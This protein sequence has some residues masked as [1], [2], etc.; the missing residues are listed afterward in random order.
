MKSYEPFESKVTA[1]DEERAAVRE[2]LKPFYEK[3][4]REVY[5]AAV[6]FVKACEAED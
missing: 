6:A 1:T 4:R 3:K 5:E 2:A